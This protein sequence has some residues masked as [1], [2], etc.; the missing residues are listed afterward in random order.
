MSFNELNAV[1]NFI[2]HRLAGVNLNR[3]EPNK[4]DY[5]VFYFPL[6]ISYCHGKTP[7]RFRLTDPANHVPG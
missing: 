3:E 7:Y 4:E 6:A 2:L 1:E 5:E